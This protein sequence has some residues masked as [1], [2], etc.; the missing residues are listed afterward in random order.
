V[1]TITIRLPDDLAEDV[2]DRA[3]SEYRS[4]SNLVRRAVIFYLD[5][6]DGADNV[7]SDVPPAAS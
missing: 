4:V 1:E 3:E 7:R 6:A 5:H 2:K